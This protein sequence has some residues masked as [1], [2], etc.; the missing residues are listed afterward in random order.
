MLGLTVSESP[1][2]LSHPRAICERIRQLCLQLVCNSSTSHTP[3]V[4]TLVPAT[5]SC[6]L[7][8][9]GHLLHPTSPLLHSQPGHPGLSRILPL[10]RS[11]PSSGSGLTQPKLSPKGPHLPPPSP[12]P[13]HCRQASSLPLLRHTTGTPT[14]GGTHAPWSVSPQVASW[15][16]PL[17]APFN[18]YLVRKTFL[19]H[20]SKL[21][22]SPSPS[23]R[24]PLTLQH[25]ICSFVFPLFPLDCS[26]HRG[27]KFVFFPA[28]SLVSRT[29]PGTQKNS[30]HIC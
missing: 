24:W 6:Y 7:N 13:L 12:A 18:C 21:A 2:L 10:L 25:A 23:F 4:T 27:R 16:S 17:S 5:I 14:S 30:L 15:L 22:V 11:T 1:F 20:S 9:M 28:L 8:V 26:H 19:D 29:I 3:T